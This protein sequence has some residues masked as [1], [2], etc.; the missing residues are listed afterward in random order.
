MKKLVT[1]DIFSALRVIKTANAKEALK[2]VLAKANTKNAREVGI[3]V[4]L[5]LMDCAAEQKCEKAVY[6]FLSTP[7]E[8][9]DEEVASLSLAELI[10]KLKE[11]AKENDLS[12]F[13]KQLSDMTSTN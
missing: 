13:F 8:M 10:N 12:S 5:T 4:I 11:L 3:D 9:K 2:P 7:F 1:S 6:A